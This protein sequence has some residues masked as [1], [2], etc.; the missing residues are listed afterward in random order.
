MTCTRGASVKKKCGE[1]K[2]E[3]V[4]GNK[5]PC[6][7]DSAL[8]LLANLRRFV[9]GF[10][11]TLLPP[12]SRQTVESL[13]KVTETSVGI[14]STARGMKILNLGMSVFDNICIVIDV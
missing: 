6:E 7:S 1:K 5:K 2:Q 12:S 10:W 9:G 13:N 4:H 3:A 14:M 11:T 8:Y